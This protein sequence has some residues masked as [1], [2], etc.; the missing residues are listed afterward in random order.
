MTSLLDT[1]ET[2]LKNLVG[3]G[4]SYGNQTSTQQS[5]PSSTDI[6]AQSI[7]SIIAS[8]I[9]N[10][11]S[12]AAIK[13]SSGLATTSN[14]ISSAV[15]SAA[16]NA[17]STASSI[18]SSITDALSSDLTSISTSLANSMKTAGIYVLLGAVLLIAIYVFA[19]DA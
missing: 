18:T 1:L 2:G 14:S 17:G 12:T 8:N 11:L 6:E 19:K 15:S 13:A 7:Q 3:G 5:L 16:N 4:Y 10:A 9:N